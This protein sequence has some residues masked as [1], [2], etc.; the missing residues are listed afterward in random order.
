MNINKK[1]KELM[2]KY[3]KGI[4]VGELQEEIP[5]DKIRRTILS[6]MMY[7]AQVEQDNALFGHNYC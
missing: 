3:P 5:D 4:T 1:A 2:A 6:R 7:F